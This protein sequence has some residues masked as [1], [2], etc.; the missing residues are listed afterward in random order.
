MRKLAFSVLLIVFV[1]SIFAMTACS[2]SSYATNTYEIQEEFA[3]IYVDIDTADIDFL[4]SEDGRCRVVC[5]EQE[6]T[7]TGDV[8]GSV[9]TDKVFIVRTDTGRIDVPKSITGGRCEITTETGNIKIS[10]S[11]D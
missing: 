10:V 2:S 5:Y 6:K 9:L 11:S 1:T 7:Y 3:G 4:P 8:E